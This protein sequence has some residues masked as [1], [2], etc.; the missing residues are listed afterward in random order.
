MDNSIIRHLLLLEKTNK[1]IIE[2]FIM[3]ILNIML[4][5]K[6]VFSACTRILGI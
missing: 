2:P 4:V 3:I 6:W 5:K 1:A